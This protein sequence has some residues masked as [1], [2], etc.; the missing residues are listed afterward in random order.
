MIGVKIRQQWSRVAFSLALL[1]AVG[2]G[3]PGVGPSEGVVRF[4]DG[5]PVQS[6][7]VEFRALADDARYASRIASDGTFKPAAINGS[8]GLPPGKYDIVVVQIVLTEDLAIEHHDHGHT[9]PRRYADYYTSDL[10]CE[11]QEGQLDP[12]ELVVEIE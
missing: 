8:I 11:I 5:T 7:S 9:V 10:K 12:V 4:T 2:C 3:G 1:C 6:G